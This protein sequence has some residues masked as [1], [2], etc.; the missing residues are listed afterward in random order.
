[1]PS[2]TPSS[3]SFRALRRLRDNIF[4]KPI[5]RPEI[6]THSPRIP[7][8][9]PRLKPGAM[10]GMPLVLLLALS[11]LSCEKNIAKKYGGDYTFTTIAWSYCGSD[12]QCDTIEYQGTISE[13]SKHS[14]KINYAPAI[15][16]NTSC[17]G[18]HVEGTIFPNVDT[19]R[20]LTIP[21][22]GGGDYHAYFYGSFDESGNLEI[23][24]GYHGLGTGKEQ[25]VRG[26]R[27]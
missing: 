15:D 9:S 6:P 4:H 20:N 7:I 23:H 10:G 19:D 24:F 13:E 3:R 16:D 8:H 5:H 25:I 21:G 11:L 27:R 22:Y 18:L 14:L 26:K 12:Y 2:P 17:S 1:M